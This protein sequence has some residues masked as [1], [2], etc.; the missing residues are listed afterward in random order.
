MPIRPMR[1]CATPGC[2]ALV[3]RGHCPTH[4][5]EQ[6]REDIRHRGSARARGYDTRWDKASRRH[7]AQEPRCAHC[8]LEGRRGIVMGRT[9]VDHVI[10]H[11]GNEILFNDPANR[12]TLCLDHHGRKTVREQRGGCAHVGQGSLVDVGGARACVWCGAVVG[13]AS[14]AESASA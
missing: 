1:T 9:V 12:Q 11:R 8:I 4:T 10:P 14:L 2:P 3:E 6:S 13:S 7:R 5:K